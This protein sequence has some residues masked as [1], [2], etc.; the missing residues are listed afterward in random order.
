MFLRALCSRSAPIPANIAYAVESALATFASCHTVAL[1]TAMHL[2]LSI[3][4]WTACS[5]PT[6]C[7][8][9]GASRRRSLYKHCNT[10]LSL[11]ESE[12]AISQ[13]PLLACR[14][15]SLVDCPAIYFIMRP[16]T[17]GIVGGC[18]LVRSAN[19]HSSMSSSS[20]GIATAIALCPLGSAPEG[21][22]VFSAWSW[23]LSSSRSPTR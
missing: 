19:G 21:S 13:M 9:M 17:E 22:A 11:L 2:S 3:K 1:A 10:A 18:F 8:K 12:G 6:T 16:P 14:P 15:L 4:V 20:S 5:T 23:A 7:S